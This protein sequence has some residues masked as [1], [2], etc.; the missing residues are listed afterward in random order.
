MA[1]K[2]DM[3]KLLDA[4]VARLLHVTQGLHF[5]VLPPLQQAQF[6]LN[7]RIGVALSIVRDIAAETHDHWSVDSLREAMR[8]IHDLAQLV[9]AEQRMRMDDAVMQ[10]PASMRSMLGLPDDADEIEIMRVLAERTKP[11]EDDDRGDR[12]KEPA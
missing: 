7:M 2:R 8:D 11:L 1:K 10:D 4:G 5:D 6:R 12:V 9:T 3:E